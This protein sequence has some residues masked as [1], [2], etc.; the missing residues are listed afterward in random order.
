MTCPL[1]NGDSRTDLHLDGRR[2]MD[3]HLL[4]LKLPEAVLTQAEWRV[5]KKNEI[6]RNGILF[7]F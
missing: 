1:A 6:D 4:C 5:E 2:K 7:P 3:H